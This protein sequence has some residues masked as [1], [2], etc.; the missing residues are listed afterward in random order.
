MG[1][2]AYTLRVR[3]CEVDEYGFVWHGHYLAWFEAARVEMLREVGL[4]PA[5]LLEMGYL[6]PVVDIRL[7][8]K[9]PVKA[10]SEVIVLASLEPTEKAMITFHYRLIEKTTGQLCAVG[11]TA[12]VMMNRREALLYFIPDE[13]RGPLDQLIARYPARMDQPATT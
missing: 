9:K 13:V 7:T 5:R 6:V 12:H 10:D 2:F 1:E 4:T 3:F 8:C 11:S